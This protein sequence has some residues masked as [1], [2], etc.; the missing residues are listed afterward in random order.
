MNLYYISR[1]TQDKPGKS[2]IATSL[3]KIK[4]QRSYI[5]R[6]TRFLQGF[7]RYTK[8]AFDT[9]PIL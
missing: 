9:T 7:I 2:Q 1:I 6:I 4:F 5:R 3:K 8:Y